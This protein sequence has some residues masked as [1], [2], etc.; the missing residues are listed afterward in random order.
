[1]GRM[2]RWVAL[3]RGVNVGGRRSLAMSRLTELCIDAGASDV[4]TYIQSGNVVLTHAARQAGPLEDELE[5]RLAAEVGAPVDVV[6]RTAAELDAVVEANPYVG[7]V[8]SSLHVAF[9]KSEPAA[10]ALDRVDASAY[11]PERYALRGRELYLHLPDGMGRAKLPP[12]LLRSVGVAATARNW[13]TVL[14]L[15]AMAGSATG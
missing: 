11:A 1:M 6:A 4:R 9:L 15:R 5:N 3:V 8:P 10:G 7:A 13:N 12:V 2:T 14:R